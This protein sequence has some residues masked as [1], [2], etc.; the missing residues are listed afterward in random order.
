[1][2]PLVPRVWKLIHA[3]WPSA[4][5]TPGSP[6]SLDVGTVKSIP[7]PL[8]ICSAVSVHLPTGL[9]MID[10]SL[11]EIVV[12]KSSANC[13]P[14]A[15]RGTSF[16]VSPSGISPLMECLMMSAAAVPLGISES[17]CVRLSGILIWVTA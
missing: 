3:A 9:D 15:V 1:M 17:P 5:K 7:L 10:A 14:S 16:P 12:P 8:T 11:E 6:S 13:L 4:M 2:T